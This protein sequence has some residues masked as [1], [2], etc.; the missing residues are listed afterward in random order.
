[1]K[2]YLP[3]Y[4]IFVC[5]IF[6]L[7]SFKASAISCQELAKIAD[8]NSGISTGFT[9]EKGRFYRFKKEMFQNSVV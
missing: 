6:L 2:N 7:C 1:M 3:I 5:S 4:K 8:E 9:N